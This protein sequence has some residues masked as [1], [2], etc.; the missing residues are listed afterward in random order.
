MKDPNQ[1]RPGYKSTTVGW[2][3][4][5]WECH[6]GADITQTIS[7]GSSPNWQGFNY[8]S[9]GMLFVTSENVREGYLDVTLPKYLP[10]AFHTKLKR[11]Q[12]KRNDI[13][14]NLVGASIGR[15]CL[16]ERE[17]GPANVNQAV[18]VFRV[19]NNTLPKYVA[20]CMQAP[21]TIRRI[22]NMQVD[23]AR[24]N[25][26]LTDLRDFIVPLPTLAEQ[27]TIV[28]I[29]SAW[30]VAID[31][32]RALL[33]ADKRRK[34]VLAQQLLTGEKRLPGYK[35][36]W[37]GKKLHSITERVNE[38]P[39]LTD[40]YPVL[41][42]TAG[43]GFVSQQEKFSKVIAGRHIEHYILLKKG[44]FSYNK[45]NSYRY[46]Q[47]CAYRLRE[48]DEGLV[49]DVFYSFRIK[50]NL[51]EPEFVEQF[52]M[53]DLHGKQLRNWVNTG[54]RNNGLLNLNASDFFS[55]VVPCPDIDEQRAIAAILTTVDDEIRSLDAQVKA[56]G[57]Q[58]K[59][60]MQQ[61]LTGELRVQ[62]T[63]KASQ[64][65]NV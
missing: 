38:S 30:D 11:T 56:L 41:S 24:P 35:G 31:Q 46:P 6:T 53:A 54:V 14:I 22:L 4:E 16:V 50:T 51:A 36:K 43:S 52:F 55:L 42:I 5:T 12:L 19:N 48:Y 59:G 61:L 58:K 27:H 7:K 1:N 39:A 29:L 20:Y 47:G 63:N 18:A 26:S 21:N 45:G 60:L 2:I 8:S 34:K 33:A 10:L 65:E 25:I 32:T 13:L 28:A 3:P 57:R 44:E 15:S 23:A 64:N 49:P 40:G 9:S 17:L 37:D 62:A